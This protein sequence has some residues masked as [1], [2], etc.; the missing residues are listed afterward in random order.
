MGR[1]KRICNVGKQMLAPEQGDRKLRRR[2]KFKRFSCEA[3]KVEST[4]MVF[5]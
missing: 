3:Q 4:I 1:A 5:R 2:G